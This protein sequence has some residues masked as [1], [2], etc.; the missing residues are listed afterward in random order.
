VADVGALLG[1]ERALALCRACDEVI[2]V[3]MA[4]TTQGE[5][6]ARAQRL[7]QRA[8]AHVLGVVVSDPQGEF[9]RDDA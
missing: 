5:A 9:A 3:V 7:L 2:L 1:D 4:G 8:G 6:V